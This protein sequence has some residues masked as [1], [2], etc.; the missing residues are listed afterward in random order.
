MSHPELYS[1]RAVAIA[2][3]DFATAPVLIPGTPAS[4]TSAPA[5]GTGATGGAYDTAGH[6]DTAIASINAIG[7]ALEDAGFITFT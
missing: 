6:R 5:G 4:V 1:P 2:S 3:D 7:Q